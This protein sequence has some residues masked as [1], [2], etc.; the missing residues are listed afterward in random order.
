MGI[1]KSNL[2][3][4]IIYGIISGLVYAITLA[5]IDYFREKDFDLIKFILGF[6]LFG[7]AMLIAVKINK[8]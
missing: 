6:V 5:L 7:I 1:N 2:W 3:S 8:K 4:K